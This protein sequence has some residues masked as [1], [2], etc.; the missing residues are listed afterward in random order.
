MQDCFAV[1]SH[2]LIDVFVVQYIIRMDA[3]DVRYALKLQVIAV[4]FHV[5]MISKDPYK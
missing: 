1:S 2:H 3:T 5:Y 4:V